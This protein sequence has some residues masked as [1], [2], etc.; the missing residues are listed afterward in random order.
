MTPEQYISPET[1][2]AM[3]IEQNLEKMRS[4]NGEMRRV[5]KDESV[6]GNAG[7]AEIDGERFPCLGVNAFYDR[8]T[9]EIKAFGNIQSIRPEIVD[10]PNYRRFAFRIISPNFDSRKRYY[11]IVNVFYYGPILSLEIAENPQTEAEDVIKETAEKYNIQ[12]AKNFDDLY[13]ILKATGNLKSITHPVSFTP[14]QLIDKIERVRAGK[15]TPEH[16]TRR[17]GL[18]DKVIE[19]MAQK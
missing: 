2:R 13:F 16:I 6:G 14:E 19:L 12:K 7:S 15:L 1:R 5:I 18:R 8:Q 17:G 10:N 3:I 9:G 4:P 11:L